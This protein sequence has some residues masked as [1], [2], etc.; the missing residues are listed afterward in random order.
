MIRELRIIVAGSRNFKDYQLLSDTLM[1]YLEDMDDTDVVDNPSQVKF[2][3]GTA[4]GADSLGEQFAYTYE[5]EVVRF[6]ADWDTYGKSAGY[7]R[8]VEMA[9]YASEAYGVLF[10]FWDGN[11]KG[12]KHMIDL[13]KRYGL[14]VHV[15]KYKEFT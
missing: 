15:V 3:S 14:E 4:R 6:P 12:T 2:I 7:R 1:Q 5:Y 11:S 10:A 9:K 13:A 8:N